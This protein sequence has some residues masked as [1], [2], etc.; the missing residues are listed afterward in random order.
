MKRLGE[1]LI[2]WLAVLIFVPM[3]VR[4]IRWCSEFGFTEYED[5]DRDRGLWR[6]L[7]RLHIV[8]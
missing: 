2:D 4:L 7:Q 8:R 6:L 5:G 3:F 1:C